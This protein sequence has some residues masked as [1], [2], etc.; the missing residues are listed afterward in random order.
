M[1]QNQLAEAGITVGEEDVW[2]EIVNASFVQ[3]NPQFLNE[4]GLFDENKFKQFL[5]DTEENN[6]GLW[7]QWSNYMNNV[8]DNA[9]RNTYNNLVNAGLGATLK[10]G[11]TEYFI[12][13]TKLDAEFVYVPYTSIAD[14]LVS[15]SKS[16]IQDYVKANANDFKVEES[17]DISYVKFDITP[18]TEDEDY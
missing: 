6:K 15:V 18:T 14:S 16:E 4:V 10:E 17:R 9:E 5:K 1:Y 3:S 7:S 13:N 11:E 8:R 12:E 2:N